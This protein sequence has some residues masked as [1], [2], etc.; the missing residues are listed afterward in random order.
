[1]LLYRVLIRLPLQ[2][3][4]EINDVY[5]KNLHEPLHFSHNNIGPEVARNLVSRLLDRD[6]KRGLGVNAADEIKAHYLS[7]VSTDESCLITSINRASSLM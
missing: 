1:V 5:Q 4:V 2:Y 6:P 7:I 3:D